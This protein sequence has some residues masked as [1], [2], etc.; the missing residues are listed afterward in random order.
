M[1]RKLTKSYFNIGITSIVLI[2]VMLCLLTFSVLSLVSARADLKL[3]TKSASHT[4]DYYTA[5]NE[6]T[7]ILFKV[8][9]CM[10]EYLSSSDE[11]AFYTAVRNELEGTDGITFTDDR[12]IAYSV[13]LGEEQCL[14]VELTL[15]YSAFEDGSHYQINTWKTVSTHEWDADTTLPVFTPDSGSDNIKEE[16]K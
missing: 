8:I 10:D 3:S 6:A 4:T 2:F 16:Q 15:S 7:D 14:S 9:T 11:S 12:H 1:N 5:E 13:T